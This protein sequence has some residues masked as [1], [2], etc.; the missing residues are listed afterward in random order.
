MFLH[1]VFES[2]RRQQRRKLLAATAVALGMAVVTAMV[3]IGTDVGNKMNREL[4]AFGANIIVYPEQDTLDLN[5]GGI[6][7]NAVSEGSYLRESDLPK[8]KFIFWQN[9]ILGFAPFLPVQVNLRATEASGSLPVPSQPVQF[10]GT[11][12]HKQITYGTQSITTGVPQTHPWWRVQGEWPADESTDVL[13]GIALANSL[14]V[15]AGTTIW[16]N[17]RTTHVS[18]ILSTGQQEDNEIVGPLR[19]AQ[20]LLGRPDVVRRIYVSALTKPEDAFARRNPDSLS[21]PLR[22]R[23]YC[24]PYAN[25]IAFQIQETIPHAHAEQIRRVAQNEGRV[26]E[27]ISGLMWLVVIAALLAAG[28][29]VS[30]AMTTAIL[31]RRREIG[32]MKSMGATR[33]AVASLFLA[34]AAVLAFAA[35]ILGFGVGA[36]FAHELGR[37][38]FGSPIGVD[39]VLLP[40]VLAIAVLITASGSAVSIQRATKFDPAVVLRGDG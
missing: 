30:S 14:H 10:I 22:D 9:N 20:A 5:V 37:S 21:G 27:R 32:L 25:S 6:A 15:A 1:L 4:K 3:A 23:W 18:G 24:T 35:G 26:L 11:Y 33:G 40:I 31:E 17:D 38:I 13:L 28:L 34:E 7:V 36:I 19:M 2:F 8:L 39:P 12:F 29:A 16:I